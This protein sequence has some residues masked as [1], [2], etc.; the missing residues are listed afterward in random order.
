VI[1]AVNGTSISSSS[2]LVEIVGNASVGEELTLSIYRQGEELTLTLTVGETRESALPEAETAD[3][4]TSG[5]INGSMHGR[6]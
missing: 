5:G 3:T 4:Q 2:E 6:N 1:Y